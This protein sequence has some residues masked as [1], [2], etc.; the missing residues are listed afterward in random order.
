MA[1]FEDLKGKWITNKTGR[2][3]SITRIEQVLIPI[4]QRMEHTRHRDVKSYY[5]YNKDDKSM[6]DKAIQH[7]IVVKYINGRPLT[8]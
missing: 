8:Y 7:T 1:D 4:E 6:V 3:V 2:D 5:N